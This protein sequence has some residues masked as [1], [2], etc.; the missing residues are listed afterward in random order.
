MPGLEDRGPRGCL[1]DLVDDATNTTL[2]RLG[3]EET[4][5]AAAGALRAWI[6][7]YG[8]PRALYVDWKSLYKGARAREQLGGEE[9]VTQFGRMCAELG[10]E[11]IAANSPQAK[12]RVERV[13]GTHQ[14]RL[15]KKL[16]C[17]Q[18][19]TLAGANAYLE[20]SYLGEHNGR[21]A[22][23]AERPEDYHRRTPSKAELD[24]I[25]RV[26]SER[27]VSEDW[28]V[29]YENRFFQL[30]RQRQHYAP[31]EGKV[32]VYE[33]GEGKL[34]IEYR[35]VFDFPVLPTRRESNPTAPKSPPASVSPSRFEGSL[36]TG[37]RLRNNPRS[38]HISAALPSVR[39]P[40]NL[41]GNLACASHAH[42]P[43]RGLG[44][45]QLLVLFHV[46]IGA[47]RHQILQTVVPE[48][49]SV[50]PVMDLKIFHG[51]A[52]LAP[53]LV[54]PEHTLHQTTISG[55]RKFDSLDLLQH[56]GR[57]SVGVA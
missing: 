45:R 47:Q 32:Q 52:F 15:V 14:D 4:I 17:A 6:E 48:L 27:R 53:P 10:I 26:Q 44:I 49:A 22:R 3:E 39:F 46:A 51:S 8:V 11:I 40:I 2:A 25:F 21:F 36:S 13:H 56:S 33:S 57:L 23:P 7:R 9:P 16:R 31:A 1:M 54:P 24:R 18:I 55:L 37:I 12:G 50:F 29:R 28:V 5:W 19:A 30:E 35:V 42:L 20:E 43:H 38:T 34:T 41:V